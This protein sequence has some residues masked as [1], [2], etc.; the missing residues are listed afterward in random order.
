MQIMLYNGGGVEIS[1]VDSSGAR[2]CMGQY[3]THRAHEDDSVACARRLA[4]AWNAC[5][6]IS[7]ADLE[8]LGAG[9]L[10]KINVARDVL[11]EKL[12]AADARFSA[13]APRIA[14]ALNACISIPTDKLVALGMDSFA[15]NQATLVSALE[16]LAN[17]DTKLAA[18][19]AAAAAEKP[20]SDFQ[21]D[22]GIN[23]VDQINR[24]REGSMEL[25][26][27]HGALRT[28]VEQAIELLRE[29]HPVD[30]DQ[31]R[32]IIAF[33]EAKHEQPADAESS[34]LAQANA[35]IALATA[36]RVVLTVTQ[37]PLKPLAM[38][39]YRTVASVRPMR[40]RSQ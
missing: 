4:L 10:A 11:R 8:A 34:I 38:G 2:E 23:M 1:L 6:G 28:Q 12:A 26:H 7:N 20:A 33:L 21:I 36:S 5:D 3:N 17:R 15:N 24:L 14:A 31:A 40:V 35:L 27:A 25:L 16:A 13:T 9:S 22:D 30:L 29:V 32:R 39:N 37:E 18:A 19:A